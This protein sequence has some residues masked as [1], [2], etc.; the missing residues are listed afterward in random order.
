VVR[1]APGDTGIVHVD[2]S[3]WYHVVSVYDQTAQTATIYINGEQQAQGS[4]T[5]TP[6]LFS[7]SPVQIGLYADPSYT[8]TAWEGYLSGLLLHRR[9]SPVTH[10]IRTL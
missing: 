2:Q 10:S 5:G 6:S 7:Q 1:A 4:A 9:S 3:A 8:G